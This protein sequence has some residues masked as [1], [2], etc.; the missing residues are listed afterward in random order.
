MNNLMY[1]TKKITLSLITIF[2]LTFGLQ[3]CSA[4]SKIN[5]TVDST[6]GS[7]QILMRTFMEESNIRGASVAL[8]DNQKTLWSEGFGWL[9]SDE[10]QRVNTQTIFSIQSMSKTFTATAVMLA[11]Q[12]G[13]LDLDKPIT[14]YLPDFRINSCFEKDPEKKITLRLLLGC[15][16]G[17]T[18]DA[19]IGNSFNASFSS[20]E[21]HYRSISD[22]WLKSPVGTQYFYSNL[23]FDL[24]AYIIEK[25]SGMTFSEYLERKIFQ[26]LS[27][28]STTV[29]AKR[30]LE[31]QN[32]AEGSIFGLKKLPAIVPMIGAGGIYSN[33][34]DLIKF[35]QFHLNYG[36]YGGQ[37]MLRKEHVVEMY[38]PIH[39]DSYAL[40]IRIVDEGVTYAFNHNGGGFGFRSSMKWF[41]EHNIGVIILTNCLYSNGIYETA[42]TI[43]D[44]YIKRGL[45]KKD[46]LSDKF[47][48]IKYFK[49]TKESKKIQISASTVSQCAG[50]SVYRPSWDKYT[51]TYLVKMS[52]GFEFT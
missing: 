32:R 20:Y 39:I 22:T 38:K 21:E 10:K 40:G 23:G 43:L 7:Y 50:D 19:P 12:E 35:V 24:A 4:D 6:F 8:F 2:L 33:A 42:S 9:N 14:V 25:I 52:G 48:P 30:I 16:A 44:D 34:E 5:T 18:H 45:A 31:I 51:G 17:F 28:Y 15:T 37:Q 36:S 41:P 27:M 26:P 3:S 29:D 1:P 13:L 47:N 11:V 49:E 46:T